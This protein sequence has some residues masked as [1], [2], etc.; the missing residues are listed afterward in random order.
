MVQELLKIHY[1]DRMNLIDAGDAWTLL[2]ETPRH[3]QDEVTFTDSSGTLCVN[4][5]IAEDYK[6]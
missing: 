3:Y 2:L 4:C 1:P 5:S 6:S